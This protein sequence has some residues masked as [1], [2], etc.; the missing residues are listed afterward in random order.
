[1]EFKTVIALRNTVCG[2]GIEIVENHVPQKLHLSSFIRKTKSNINLRNSF[3]QVSYTLNEI[4]KMRQSSWPCGKKIIIF[5]FCLFLFAF[6]FF[7]RT[8]IHSLFKS[9]FCICPRCKVT[10]RWYDPLAEAFLPF[11]LLLLLFCFYFD[12]ERIPVSNTV[13][14]VFRQI[15]GLFLNNQRMKWVQFHKVVKHQKKCSAEKKLA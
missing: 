12:H 8:F 9:I 3:I 13:N 10:P 14:R 11:R 7:M 15:P 5:F 1:M 6:R 2:Y 4:P